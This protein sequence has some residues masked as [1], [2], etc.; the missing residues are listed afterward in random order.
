M[1]KSVVSLEVIL[2]PGIESIEGDIIPL[3]SYVIIIPIFQL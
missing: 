1:G 2:L 3:G